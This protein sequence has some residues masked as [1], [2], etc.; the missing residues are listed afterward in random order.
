[1][2]YMSYL[3]RQER[4][5]LLGFASYDDYTKST[6]WKAKRA[7]LRRSGRKY[8]CY[9]C[10]KP[11]TRRDRLQAHHRTY[12]RLGE[13]DLDDLLWLCGACHIKSHELEE[14]GQ[15]SLWT[16]A[17]ALRSVAMEELDLAYRKNKNG[18]PIFGGK[19]FGR[20]PPSGRKRDHGKV[21]ATAAGKERKAQQCSMCE[22]GAVF[23]GKC[24]KHM[25]S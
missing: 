4:L 23:S 9:V 22:E 8:R 6:L 1:M 5:S 15:E 16:C 20:R 2:K 17:D 21:K 12:E 24:F 14:S 19:K 10:N 3:H 7:E 18:K 13:E 11:S 25:R